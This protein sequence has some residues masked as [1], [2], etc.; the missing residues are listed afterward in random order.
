LVEEVE[1]ELEEL[2]EELELVDVPNP[3][4]L[5][6]NP[7]TKLPPPPEEDPDPP[8]AEPPRPPSPTGTTNT[9]G[10]LSPC[11]FCPRPSRS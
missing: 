7:E 3:G 1:E 11:R 5:D 6:V 4:M 2:E 8:E 9:S 10:E